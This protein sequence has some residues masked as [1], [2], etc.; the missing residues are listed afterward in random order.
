M[1]FQKVQLSKRYTLC[2]LTL[3][4]SLCVRKMV[5]KPETTQVGIQL[6]PLVVA[7]GIRMKQVIKGGKLSPV[8]GNQYQKEWRLCPDK[9]AFPAIGLKLIHSKKRTAASHNRTTGKQTETSAG[10][11][12]YLPD[13]TVSPA[14]KN[15]SYTVSYN[16]ESQ[17]TER[18][19]NRG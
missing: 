10:R 17:Y 12:Y 18:E 14:L 19:S 15:A 1:S 6:I 4:K 8:F 9:P 7:W 13:K 3:K 2:A 11:T 5:F 16:K